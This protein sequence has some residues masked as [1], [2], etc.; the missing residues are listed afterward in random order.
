MGFMFHNST[1]WRFNQ[2]SRPSITDDQ[3]KQRA[4]SFAAEY[5]RCKGSDT[6]SF[7]RVAI[8]TNDSAGRVTYNAGKALANRVDE[9]NAWLNAN[10]YS[11]V[12]GIFGAN[13]IEL[14]WGPPAEAKDWADGYRDNT[15]TIYYDTGDAAG[16]SSTQQAGRECG[17]ANYPGWTASDV[18]YV[19]DKLG[20]MPL[21]QIYREDEAQARQWKWLSVFAYEVKGGKM[22]IRTSATQHAACA[23]LG[24]CAGVDNTAAEGYT[25]LFE[26]LDSDQRTAV[27]ASSLMAT[28]WKWT[29]P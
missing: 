20:A 15:Y 3:A 8:G 14:D 21:P 2:F 10:G 19:S 24:G 18:W 26:W 22:A 28:D 7:V 16:C 4:H 9:A 13:D 12:V 1:G 17:T 29:D 23:Q 27:P 11:G 25:Q 5:Y 6:S